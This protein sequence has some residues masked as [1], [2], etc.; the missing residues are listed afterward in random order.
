MLRH[1]VQEK[2]EGISRYLQSTP[3]VDARRMEAAIA[4]MP[5]GFQVYTRP[6]AGGGSPPRGWSPCFVCLV[7]PSL[8][9]L[10]HCRA[11]CW[12]AAFRGPRSCGAYPRKR[13]RPVQA[14]RTPAYL[15]EGRT[16]HALPGAVGSHPAA[17]TPTTR[18]TTQPFAAVAPPSAWSAVPATQKSNA[19]A[20]QPGG[21]RAE[22]DACTLGSRRMASG[23]HKAEIRLRLHEAEIASFPRIL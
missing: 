20:R 11:R 21:A 9:A 22:R 13:R 19:V 15:A 10:T 17:R 2:V 16:A 14:W 7:Y 1:A 12:L 5:Q 18:S 8:T 4:R 3:S 6:L 23:R